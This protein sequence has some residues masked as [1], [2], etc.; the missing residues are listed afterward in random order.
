M[1]SVSPELRAL[2]LQPLEMPGT[3]LEYLTGSAY[4]WCPEAELLSRT[5]L[6]PGLIDEGWSNPYRTTV[7]PFT[8]DTVVSQL[9][10]QSNRRRAYLVIQNKGPGNM[11]VNFGMAA[12]ALNGV[13]LVPTQS[14]E[15]IG[16]EQGGAFVPPDSI[17]ALTDL[18][19][20]TGVIV[21]GVAL[22][23]PPTLQ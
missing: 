4:P 1:G 3:A 14:W 6:D 2:L 20:T 9:F 15:I 19:G 22:P 17:Y 10:V 23:R 8:P 21:E 13:T 11:F 12:D 7:F 18:A 16:G 5:P